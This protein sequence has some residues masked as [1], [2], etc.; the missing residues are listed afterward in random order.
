MPGYLPRQWI[1]AGCSCGTGSTRRVATRR[2]ATRRVAT[3]RVATR[4]VATRAG[5]IICGCRV[6]R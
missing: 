1:V 6:G 5:R 4:R 2:V 3:R